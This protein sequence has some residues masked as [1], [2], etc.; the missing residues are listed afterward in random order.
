MAQKR[1]EGSQVA[2][3]SVFASLF[4]LV[5]LYY[6]KNNTVIKQVEW[7]VATTTAG[8]YTADLKISYS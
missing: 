1:K 4:F 8:D 6:L 2:C 7:D 3:I 5:M